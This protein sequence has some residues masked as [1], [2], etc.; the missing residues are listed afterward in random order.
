MVLTGGGGGVDRL[1]GVRG[2][3]IGGGGGA[4]RGNGAIDGGWRDK[5]ERGRGFG[6]G[7]RGAEAGAGG[8]AIERAG[9]VGRG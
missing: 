9:I 6:S 7:G 1:G 2:A 8:G 5:L 3:G 4:P